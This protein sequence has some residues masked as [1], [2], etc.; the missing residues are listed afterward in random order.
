MG[1]SQTWLDSATEYK[2]LF[3]ASI[4]TYEISNET[5]VGATD[6]ATPKLFNCCDVEEGFAQD[7]SM[8]A[9]G[10]LR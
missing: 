3:Q 1:V 9:G 7:R 2:Y 4:Y 8:I 5:N 10:G 6:P